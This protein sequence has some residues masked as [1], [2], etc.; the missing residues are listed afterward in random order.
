MCPCS[1][2]NSLSRPI[3][4]V[5][6]LFRLI[7]FICSYSLS[8]SRSLSLT[9]SIS[10]VPPFCTL[11]FFV[12]GAFRA[13]FIPIPF[14]VYTFVHVSFC[15]SLSSQF[16]T[17]R[18]L[19]L[20]YVFFPISSWMSR[21]CKYVFML[22][23]CVIQ[24]CYRSVNRRLLL[25]DLVIRSLVLTIPVSMNRLKRLVSWHSCAQRDSNFPLCDVPMVIKLCRHGCH[26]DAHRGC[27]FRRAF[28]YLDEVL[29]CRLLLSRLSLNVRCLLVVLT[30]TG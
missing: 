11:S 10:L 29:V 27:R 21:I 8:H 26:G 16:G 28:I 23:Y 4:F 5:S 12:F 30:S 7:H 20:G 1:V 9:L 6:Y 17:F 15:M 24:C 18:A 19:F 3:F 13:L 14:R 25:L 2:S 22:L